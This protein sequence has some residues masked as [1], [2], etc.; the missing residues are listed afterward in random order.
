MFYR[1]F[2]SCHISILDLIYKQYTVNESTYFCSWKE[3]H[4]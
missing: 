1:N 2:V 3:L 4:Y